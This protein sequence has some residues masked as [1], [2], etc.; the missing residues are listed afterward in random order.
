MILLVIT[1]PRASA[2]QNIFSVNRGERP[3]IHLDQL[4]KNSFEQGKLWIKLKDSVYDE[5]AE[6]LSTRQSS[7]YAVTGRKELDTLN[8]QLNA[9]AYQ[10]LFGGLSQSKSGREAFTEKHQAWGFHQWFEVILDDKTDVIEAVKRYAK[11]ADVETAEPVYQKT[12]ISSDL[13]SEISDPKGNNSNGRSSAWVPDDLQYTSQWHYKNTGQQN[14]TPGSDIS[15]EEAWTIEKGNPNVIVAIIDGG[16][17]IDHPDLQGNIWEGIGY[18]FVNNSS[19]IIPHNHGTHVAGTVA[20]MSNNSIG[21]AGIAGGSGLGDG[22]RLMSCQVFTSNGNGGFHLAPIYAADNGA[23]ISQNSWAYTNAGVYEQAVLDA[24][25]YFN[26]NGGGTALNGGISIFAAGNSNAS[27]LWYPACYS[28]T[29]AV[30]ATNNQDM[31][32]WYSNYDTWVDISAP[33]GETNQVNAAGVLSTLTNN[34]YGFYQGTSMACPHVSGVAALIVS[35]A[36]GLLTS[37]NL[38]DILRNSADNHYPVNPGFSGM[39]GSGRLNAYEA[40]IQTQL[41]LN[42]VMNPQCFNATTLCTNT[43]ELA[44]VK[45]VSNHDVLLACSPDNVF[46]Q[47]AESIGYSIGD[48]IPGGGEVIYTGNATSFLHQNL[49]VGTQY[50]YK[51]WSFNS[52]L[53]YSSGKTTSAVTHC[54]PVTELPFSENF[55]QGTVIPV[56]WDVADHIGNGQ[57]WKVGT[58]VGKVAGTTGNVAYLNS[59]AYGYGNSQNSDLITQT[60]DLTNYQNVNLRFWHYF[61]QYQAS[62]TAT[63][64]YSIDNGQTWV[65]IQTWTSN[66]ANPA[67][68]N[69]VIPAVAGKQNVKFKWNF[70]GNWG[71]YWSIDDVLISGTYSPPPAIPN[72]KAEPTTA[73]VGET[74]SF[75]ETVGNPNVSVWAWNFGEGAVPATAN[76]MGPHQVT[77][78]NPG[79]KTV[80]LTIDGSNT[81]V[82]EN[83]IYVKDYFNLTITTNGPGI[84]LVNGIPYC[85]TMTFPEGSTVELHA[86]GDENAVFTGWCP[87]MGCITPVSVLINQN[88]TITANFSYYASAIFS[89]GDIPTDIRFPDSAAA[90]SCAE[91]LIL[92]IPA[93]AHVTGVNVNYQMS[94]SNGGKISEQVSMIK[95]HANNS[96]IELPLNYGVGDA[97]GSYQYIM[98]GLDFLNNISGPANIIFEM[99]AGRTNMGAG[100]DATYNKVDNNTWSVMVLYDLIPSAPEVETLPF[101]NLAPCSVQVGGIVN[102]DGGNELI[103]RG[104]YWGTEPNPE[105]NGV[106]LERGVGL[107]EFYSILESLQSGTTYYYRAYAENNVGIAFG[108]ELS[109]TTIA[110]PEVITGLA[111]D[112]TS[113]SAV[114]MIEILSDGG[115][116]ITSA[117]ISWG[118]DPT[119]EFQEAEMIVQPTTGSYLLE[120]SELIPST[121]YYYLAFAINAVGKTTGILATF[122]TLDPVGLPGSLWLEDIIVENGKD[123]CYS[124]TEQI[125]LAGEGKFYTVE[126]GAIVEIIAGQSILFLPGTTITEG[127][128]FIARI[129]TDGSY[130]DKPENLMASAAVEEEPEELIKA[131]KKHSILTLFPNPGNG[132]INLSFDGSY[133]N[134]MTQITVFNMLGEKIQEQTLVEGQAL[135]LTPAQPGMY[136]LHIVRGTEV[137]IEK[138]LKR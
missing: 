43:I 47:P 93:A 100:C 38:A 35:N 14:G 115:A 112:I 21:V 25:D 3:P 69:Q 113:N 78:T 23:A 111:S 8:K 117:G 119:M 107:G 88:K 27:G 4:S 106:Q 1:L 46:G 103:Q 85:E 121:Q 55:N 133:G 82:K 32:A 94:A 52:Q 87:V 67:L 76:C 60:L 16:I 137:F 110:K 122:V 20:A 37:A 50:Y 95:C 44:W 17:Q 40:L 92:E 39:L 45:N 29:F 30:A 98:Q 65:T 128:H 5:V 66:T 68:F 56:C 13:I 125:I 53:V 28:G 75:S 132:I 74:I 63:L 136:V 24:I 15:L 105:N 90:S 124:A 6:S 64:A 97:E 138:Y 129:T 108:S 26:A 48:L 126:Y 131:E 31:K 57:V 130:C 7:E 70:T 80:S 101:V 79:Y 83:Y 89:E 99:H 41:L 9:L 33:G 120:I 134:D 104:I 22:V 102:C 96:S 2:A 81:E 109:F 58:F 42:S 51:I 84:V 61:R 34:A 59:S 91:I 77:Y 127:S 123:T 36:Y 54:Y 118:T 116:E 86:V 18:N 11:L 10:A 12:L 49:A 135:Y 73:F 62:S 72:F 19:T 71:Y 114:V